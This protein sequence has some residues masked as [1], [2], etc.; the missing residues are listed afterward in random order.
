M[1]SR[2][3]PPSRNRWSDI[4]NVA[5]VVLIF[6]ASILFFG[7]IGGRAGSFAVLF[8]WLVWMSGILHATRP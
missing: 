4:A 6:G 1:Q 8:A 7:H 3:K 5:L 2:Q